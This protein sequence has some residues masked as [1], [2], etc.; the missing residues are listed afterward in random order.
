[1]KTV[2]TETENKPDFDQL[3]NQLQANNKRTLGYSRS[4]FLW[5]WLAIGLL[6]IL[7]CFTIL[8]ALRNAD[9][10][11][12]QTDDIARVA[13][14]TADSA[15]QSSDDIVAYM[16]G[17][18]GIPGVP[19][20]DGQDG[21]PGQPGAA[22]AGEPG[23][24][25]DQGPKGDRGEA[26]S[27]GPTGPV[28]STG[29]TGVT[30]T[31]GSTGPMGEPGGSGS[32]GSDGNDGTS[33]D[34]GATGPRGDTGPAGPMGP[35]G[36]QGPA[37]SMAALTTS[38]AVNASANDPNEPKQV[39]AQCAAGRVTGGGYAV[40]P[41]DPGIIVTASAPNANGWNATAEELSLP[42]ATNWQL[43]VFA[44]CVS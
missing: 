17:E 21:T 29:P 4:R 8:L 25:G 16:R 33:G 30:G 39:T 41:S 28:G 2:A 3:T 34:Q 37:G 43:F 27:P 1:M 36:P 9:T 5:T 23:E 35:A 42:V 10:N 31:T 22:E 12:E 6:A 38:V 11:L 15:Q 40:V 24:P 7:T 26:G 18:Q 13:Q 20:T 14:T 32:P 19:G 44:V